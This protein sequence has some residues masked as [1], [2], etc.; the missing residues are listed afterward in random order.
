MSLRAQT[1]PSLQSKLQGPQSTWDPGC[2]LRLGVS[3]F[4]GTH[5]TGTSLDAPTGL[6]Q[7]LERQAGIT[8]DLVRA[9]QGSWGFRISRGGARAVL[10]GMGET[11]E[12][13]F[14]PQSQQSQQ[15]SLADATNQLGSEQQ[16]QPVLFFPSI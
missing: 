9:E 15:G 8:P 6:R 5:A 12:S 4:P 16:E 3:A 13:I 11:G 10:G 7:R 1:P 2:D 14:W